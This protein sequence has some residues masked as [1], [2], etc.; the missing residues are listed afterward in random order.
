LTIQNRPA[1]IH[2]TKTVNFCASLRQ[3]PARHALKICLRKFF[4]PTSVGSLTLVGARKETTDRPTEIGA[5]CGF[6]NQVTHPLRPGYAPPQP[7]LADL[8]RICGQTLRTPRH[9]MKPTSIS[10]HHPRPLIGLRNILDV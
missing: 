3:L 8:R 1:G 6:A 7:P 5:P 4:A 9:P 2:Q 10:I